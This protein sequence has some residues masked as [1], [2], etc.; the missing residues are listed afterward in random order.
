MKG[1]LV[2]N[3][4]VKTLPDSISER[5]TLLMGL[6]Y[7]MPENHP[8][9]NKIREMVKLLELHVSLQQQFKIE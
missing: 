2:I 4:V 3:H 5:A 7:L 9:K 6:T 1:D 8:A